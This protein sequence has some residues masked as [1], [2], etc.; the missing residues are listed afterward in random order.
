MKT[1]RRL[2]LGI[3]EPIGHLD[4]YPNSGDNQPGCSDG[5]MKFV[6]KENQ[7]VYQGS[8]KK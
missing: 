8:S 6:K 1:I 2:G 7:S 3:I 5:M 4:F